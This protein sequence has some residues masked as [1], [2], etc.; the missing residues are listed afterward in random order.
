MIIDFCS[1]NVRGLNSKVQFIRDFIKSNKI[2]LIGL[3]ETRVKKDIAK[4]L[5]SEINRSFCWLDN[6]DYHFG[7]RIWIG[8]NKYF[9]DISVVAKSAQHITCKAF[10]KQ[11][12]VAFTI[13][14]I[15]GFNTGLARRGLWGELEHVS[16][17]VGNSA[18]VLSGDFNVCLDVNEKVGGN[19][20]WNRDMEEFRDFTLKLGITDLRFSGHLLTW[21][22]CNCNSPR[23]RKLDRVMINPGWMHLFD[24][25]SATFLNRGISD[26]SPAVTEL[27]LAKCFLPKPFKFFNFLCGHNLFL[28]TVAKC[29]STNIHGNPWFILTSKLKLVKQALKTLNSDVGNV[30]SRVA[31]TRAAL[32]GFQ[33]L[34]S[35]STHVHDLEMEKMLIADYKKSLDIEESFLKQKSRVQWLHLGDCNSGFFFN[36]CK[37]R[38]NLNKIL[39][40]SDD[41]GA[42]YDNH[43]DIAE[44]AVNHFKNLIGTE[45]PVLPFLDDLNVPQ[46]SPS[47]AEYLA[48]PFTS[49]DILDT[50]KSM[51]KNKSPGPDGFT[52]EFF[53][54]SWQ[55]VGPDVEKA[56]LHFFNTGHMPRIVNSAAV[57]LVPKIENPSYLKDYRPISCCNVLYKC[58]SK[59]ISMRL[60]SV[61]QCI[62]SPS[63]SAFL[64]GR[65][66]GDNVLLVQALCKD[67]H[68]N[69]G[70]PRCAL[71]V[72]LHKAFDSVSWTFLFEA[73]H[74]MKFP[75]NFINWVRTCITTAMFS[76]KI[77]GSLEG[78]FKG[79]SGLRQ[80]DPLSP[81][82]F[83]I[84]MEIFSA[85]LNKFTDQSNFKHHWRA[86]DLK[87]NHLIFADDLFLFSHGDVNSVAALN[88]G[89]LFFASISGLRPNWNKSSCFFAGVHTEVSNEI[90]QITRFQVG[91]LPITYLGLPLVSSKLRFSDCRP[92]ISKFCA[93]IESWTARFLSFVGRLT[94]IKAILGGII[95]YWNM[96]LFL[97][98][99]VLKTLNAIIFKF[100]WGG[101]HKSN[102]RCHH[103]LNWKTCCL[104]KEEGGLGIRN[105]FEWNEASIIFQIWRIIQPRPT[106][107]WV[108]WFRDSLLR[109]KGFW[110]ASVPYRSSWG[111][112]KIFKARDTALKFIK[113]HI[114]PNSS[115]RFWLDPWIRNRPLV[116]DFDPQT[117]S[118]AESTRLALVCDFLCDTS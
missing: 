98:I 115:F 87:I 80:G 118:N 75:E 65:S 7:G 109:N 81:Y 15:Y 94:L 106:S 2:N 72:D 59:M 57:S 86:K 18:W 70:P 23:Y 49:G 61:L 111:I 88:Q 90:L 25:S 34:L 38:W 67:Y 78:Y 60:R 101:F 51:P 104:P 36:S 58:I 20:H 28:P 8:F 33:Q 5:S 43:K 32:D 68:L 17:I 3:M 54:A 42:V 79:V 47:Q 107:I 14:F 92:L 55:I 13:S 4:I 103:K 116:W 31:Q 105:I 53:I 46:L 91:T 40:I 37:N 27:G 113:Y 16:S 50:L 11:S 84:A 114:G 29:W 117:I 96:Y 10:N 1:Y 66:I 63:Q 108:K 69:N 112:R 35:N 24:S 6:Y 56:V 26:H 52:S 64:P 100:L 62:I 9:W 83:V 71:K 74:R 85:C 22:D 45:N 82:L 97:P 19:I 21:W 93:R 39:S 89:L 95:G 76:I 73:L 110:T 41:S 44:V 30:H 102:G 77:N 48:R 99:R 12:R